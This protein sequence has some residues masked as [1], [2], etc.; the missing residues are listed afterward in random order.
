ASQPRW[1]TVNVWQSTPLAALSRKPL[2]HQD[3]QESN[4][5]ARHSLPTQGWRAAVL[6]E[7]AHWDR[8]GSPP[9]CFRWL[10]ELSKTANSQ[11]R[12]APP[13]FPALTAALVPIVAVILG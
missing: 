7:P 3:F 9:S 5:N 6:S 12:R 13:S 10:A 8:I 4:G 2:M 11:G 1:Q